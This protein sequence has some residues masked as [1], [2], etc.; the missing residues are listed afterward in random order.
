MVPALPKGKVSK[1]FTIKFFL[2]D[3]QTV[4][5]SLIYMFLISLLLFL[6]FF[7]HK[8]QLEV[9][10]RIVILSFEK[11]EAGSCDATAFSEHWQQTYCA[12]YFSFF[13]LESAWQT[14]SIHSFSQLY[15]S[16]C[17]LMPIQNSGAIFAT[18]TYNE[19]K[20]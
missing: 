1:T 11:R 18:E 13:N 3:F 8:G 16:A 4:I 5:T 14:I 10:C 19:F 20:K 17:R 7:P 12:L 6:F 2:T 15:H 9:S